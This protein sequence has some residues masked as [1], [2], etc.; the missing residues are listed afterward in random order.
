MRRL[1]LLASLALLALALGCG[2]NGD[3]VDWTAEEPQGMVADLGFRPDRDGFSFENFTDGPAGL[4]LDAGDV[5]AL[6]GEQACADGAGVAENC[7]LSAKADEFL[8]DNQRLAAGGHCE[9]LSILSLLFFSGDRDPAD[10]GSD[11]VYDLHLESN[12]ALEREILQWHATQLT[13]ESLEASLR[14]TPVEALDILADSFSG[15]GELYTLGIYNRDSTGAVVD[16]HAMVPFAI[17]HLGDGKVA[18]DVYNTNAPG[19]SSAVEIDA[20]A[21][22]WSYQGV[23]V[24]YDGSGPLELTPLS[25]RLSTA[26]TP[27]AID[28][29]MSSA[30]LACA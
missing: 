24:L 19:E 2:G 11:T 1:G 20:R 14:V 6:L 4:E 27:L 12:A 26:L 7:S 29:L 18:L 28:D 3:S 17:E 13:A 8:R 5:R 21:D 30:G 10:F 16:G 9:G 23:N 25:A 15:G 22:T